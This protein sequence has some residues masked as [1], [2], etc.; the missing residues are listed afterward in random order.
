MSLRLMRKPLV[1]LIAQACCLPLVAQAQMQA[2][3]RAT[4]AA[5]NSGQ[6][7]KPDFPRIIVRGRSPSETVIDQKQ[8][9]NEPPKDIRRL[10]DDTIGVEF[11]Q[12]GAGQLGDIEIRGMGG[13]GSFLGNASN[14]VTLEVDGMDVSQSFNFGHNMRNGRQYFDPADLKTVT[15][16]KGPGANGLA[17]NVQFRTKDPGDYIREGRRLGGEVRLGY[18]GDSRDVSAGLTLAT[19]IGQNQS[20]SLSYTRRQYHELDNKGGLDVSGPERTKSNPVDGHSHSLNGK[21]VVKPS[22]AQK[23]TLALQHFSVENQNNLLNQVGK[24]PRS[25]VETFFY[26]NTQKNQRDA[27]S[28]LHELEGSSAAFD[29]LR[30]QASVQRT[31]SEGFNT[32]ERSHPRTGRV[33]SHD[34][35]NFRINHYSLKADFGKALGDSGSIEHALSYGAKLQYSSVD[36]YALA[37]SGA[38]S[39]ERNFFPKTKQWQGGL[40]LADQISFAGSGISLTPSLHVSRIVNHP[41]VRDY[42]KPVAGTGKFSRTALGGGLVLDWLLDEHNLL[43]ASYQHSTR[44]PAYGETNAQSYGHWIGRPNPDLKPETADA[45]ELAWMNHGNF[46]RYKAAL[47]YNRYNDMVDVTCD[48]GNFNA[49]GYCEVFNVDGHSKLYGIELEGSLALDAFGLPQGLSLDAA[50]TYVKGKSASGEPL[51]RVNP[52]N[53]RLALRYADPDNRWG[54]QARLNFAA[55]KKAADLPT[56][57]SPLP[58]YGVVDLI[59]HYRLGEQFSLSGGIYN[60]ADRQYSRWVRARGANRDFYSE[61]GRYLALN[62]RYQF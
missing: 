5:S 4:E 1:I 20:A 46:G 49:D 44:L 3:M 32:Y 29:T 14:R 6:A 30:W 21:W 11:S 28:L 15:I 41:E 23:F 34:D 40:H 52:P 43:S 62:L 33:I 27:L 13:M 51:G 24:N 25:G 2:P 39:R 31:S 19:L 55:A 56:G 53:G 18:S 22:E 45:L 42:R 8:M 26:H 36:Q 47:F 16:H 60:V 38:I 57:I 59:G 58:G 37:R 9:E 10:F 17:G 54:L 12:T 48:Y 61:P 50:A 35:N 7:A